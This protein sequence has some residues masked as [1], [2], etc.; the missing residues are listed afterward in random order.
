MASMV[1]TKICV[2]DGMVIYA[3]ACGPHGR[4]T[5]YSV[6]IKLDRSD[7]GDAIFLHGR[8]DLEADLGFGSTYE[9]ALNQAAIH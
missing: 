3:G 6:G 5:G 7:V 4:G 1:R 8:A 9:L 2:P